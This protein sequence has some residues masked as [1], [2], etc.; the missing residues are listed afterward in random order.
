MVLDRLRNPEKT[1]SERDWNAHLPVH[2]VA[3]TTTAG[4]IEAIPAWIAEEERQNHL[5]MVESARTRLETADP[6]ALKTIPWDDREPF[7]PGN[8]IQWI[9]NGTHHDMIAV[10]A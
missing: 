10:L 5:A 6:F 1:L 3:P 7:F 4:I 2:G 9:S 8:R